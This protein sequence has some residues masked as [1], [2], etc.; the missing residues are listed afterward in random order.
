MNNKDL[1]KNILELVGGEQNISGLTHCA[2]RLRFVL[3]DDAK[4]DLKTLDQLEGVLKAQNSGGQ[5]QVVIGAK[6]DAVYGEVKSLTSDQF[7]GVDESADRSGPKKKRNP[8]NV[9]LETIAGIFTP[10]LPALV[11]CGMIKCVATVIAALGWLE[12]SGFLVI[13]NM[14]GDLIFYFLPFFLAV[15]AAHKFKT[16]PYLA[17]ALAAGLMH[18]TILNAAAQIADTGV[19]TIDFLG[20]PILLM[21]YSSSVIPIILAVW[22]MSYVYRFVDQ[23]IPKFLRV[24]LTPMVVLFIMI[25]LEL[26]VLGPIGSYVGDWLTQGINYL[27]STAGVLAGL[28]LGF[29]KPIMVMFGMHYALMPIQVQQVAS[30]GS[31]VLLPAALAANLAQAGAA[32]GVFVLTKSKTMKSAAGSS[33]FTALFGITEPAI[34]GVTL[35]Y[36][37]PFFAGCAAAGLVGGFYS[38]VH[39]SATAISLPGILALG[40]YT[41]DRY[42]YVVIGSVAAI[43]LGFV[44]TLMAGI[45]EDADGAQPKQQAT[46]AVDSIQ[47]AAA[48][49]VTAEQDSPQTSASSSDML[50]VSPMTGEIRP[51]SEVEDQAFAQELMGKG[52]AI[53]PTEGKVYSPF[54]GIVEALY[55]TKHAIGLKAANGVEILIHIGVD[56]VSLKGKYFNAHI[57]QGQSIKAGDLL[58]EFDPE[59]ITSAGY[60]TITSIVV[61]NMQQ[62]GDV[63]TTTSSGPVRESEALIKL[64]P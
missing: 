51:I 50:I 32:F 34:Y 45:K 16:N 3:K 35:R 62:Y 11:G 43:V 39:A 30:L 19:N 20:M 52:I 33:G 40:T 1:A 12:G 61:T 41:A 47:T 49:G 28:I 23:F 36:K 60:N 37:R 54:D 7:G 56:T 22:I 25:P 57:E 21:K 53:V 46:G 9:V 5:I 42:I 26:I 13:V 15:S 4:A 6:V 24:L 10:V 38:L 44:F 31:T 17:V 14:I 63:L 48:T 59:G 29:F 18:P 8:V 58:V 64:I 27:F 2:T 55:R